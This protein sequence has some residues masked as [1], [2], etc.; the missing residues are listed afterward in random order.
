MHQQLGPFHDVD[1][2]GFA[3]HSRGDAT[4]RDR[5]GAC[6]RSLKGS[7]VQHVPQCQDYL[8]ARTRA[9]GTGIVCAAVARVPWGP[10][11]I[12]S[13]RT[14]GYPTCGPW[15]RRVGARVHLIV[16]G[17][18]RQGGQGG[19]VGGVIVCGRHVGSAGGW[20]QSRLC[21]EEE[22][23]GEAR[24]SLDT[25]R[26]V[27]ALANPRLPLALGESRKSE[28]PHLTASPNRVTEAMAL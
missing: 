4:D 17:R 9:A 21:G 8:R 5:R 23:K 15:L 2:R 20:R 24:Q 18:W 25:T 10:A 22:V 26:K 27:H 1:A 11:P 19:E 3:S 16:R 14:L 6:K 13:E 7:A 28:P 12:A